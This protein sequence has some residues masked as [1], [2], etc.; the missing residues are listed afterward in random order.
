M[1]TTA[2]TEYASFIS[3]LESSKNYDCGESKGKFKE[4]VAESKTELSTFR[5][6]AKAIADF[7]K[8]TIMPDLK[9]IRAQ[10]PITKTEK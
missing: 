1:L 9:A 7:I 6:Q 3:K 8:N 2:A 4:M 5:T 10:K